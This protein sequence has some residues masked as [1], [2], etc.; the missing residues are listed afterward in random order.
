MFREKKTPQLIVYME[1]VIGLKQRASGS[2][3]EAFVCS[4]GKN[5]GRRA[6]LIAA[7]EIS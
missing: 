6:F 5:T 2:D 4:N 7:C 3:G 1:A